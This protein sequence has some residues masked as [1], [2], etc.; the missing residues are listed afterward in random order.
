[1]IPLFKNSKE[2]V[3]VQQTSH[4]GVGIV[5]KISEEFWCFHLLLITCNCSWKYT[6]ARPHSI[7]QHLKNDFVQVCSEAG[8]KYPLGPKFMSIQ[9]GLPSIGFGNFWNVI[10]STVASFPRNKFTD[11]ISCLIAHLLF[12]QKFRLFSLSLATIGILK[13][14]STINL[15]SSSVH[16]TRQV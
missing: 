4:L 11:S 13:Y 7:H 16:T 6:F 14:T 15:F 12:G 2:F 9:T 3:H 8:N 1:M 10:L 5:L